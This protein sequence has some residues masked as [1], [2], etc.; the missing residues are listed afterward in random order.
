[1][2]YEYNITKV[3]L[4]NDIYDTIDDIPFYLDN[5]YD[6]NDKL[7]LIALSRI[8]INSKQACENISATEFDRIAY[9][10]D[11]FHDMV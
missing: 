7:K 6:K 1:M 10:A 4:T 9:Y 2:V 5:F 3:Y 11:H 8:E